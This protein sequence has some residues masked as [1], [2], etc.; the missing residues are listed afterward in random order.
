MSTIQILQLVAL[1]PSLIFGILLVRYLFK[2][3]MER[4]DNYAL[5]TFEILNRRD[6]DDL[7]DDA[8][9]M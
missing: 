7:D 3:K 1:I 5:K 8:F 6:E 2:R 4:A 9:P